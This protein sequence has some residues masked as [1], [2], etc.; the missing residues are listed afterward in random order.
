MR[1]GRLF[2]QLSLFYV[3]V[4]GTVLVLDWLFPAFGQ[5]L[6]IGGAEGLL[7]GDGGDPF[8]TT[9]IGATK[10]GNLTDSLAYLFIAVVGMRC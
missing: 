2:L 8:D 5:F 9:A 7:A 1:I 10:V 6:P 4:T 3:L